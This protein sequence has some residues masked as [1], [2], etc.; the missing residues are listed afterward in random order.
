MTQSFEGLK[1][2]RLIGHTIHPCG[3]NKTKTP[4]IKTQALVPLPVE[5]RDLIQ[6]R[7]T[8]AIGSNSHG[9]ETQIK[10]TDSESFFNLAAQMM[11]SNDQEFIEISHRMA[12]SLAD[13]HTN[14]RWPGGIQFLISGKIGAHQKPFLAAIKAETDKGLNFTE[15]NGAVALQVVKNM[16]LS[17]SQKLYKIGMLIEINYEPAIDGVGFKIENY[18]SHL[19][20]HLLTRTE[21]RNAAGYFYRDF[22]GMD[23]TGSSRFQTRLFFESTK[24]YINAAPIDHDK[25]LDLL[26]ALRV[27]LRSEK[28]SITVRNF[29]EEHIPEELRENYVTSMGDNGVPTTAIIKDVEYIKSKLRRNR[30]INFNSGVNIQVPSGKV[31]NDFVEIGGLDDGF[32]SVRIRGVVQDRD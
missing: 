11:R 4:P 25:K 31:V 32:T 10:K 17:Q 19:F 26:E 22:L 8:E 24:I 18:S 7:I 16:L 3:K 1:I 21:T 12:D 15:S 28:Q 13:A 5:T 14:P 20:D 9:V 23:I 30:K 2:E 6:L 29:A 27:E